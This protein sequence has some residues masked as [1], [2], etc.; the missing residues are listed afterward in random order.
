[1]CFAAVVVKLKTLRRRLL[2]G[3]DT[4]TSTM[5]S[6]GKLVEIAEPAV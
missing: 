6:V 3:V 2:K 1:V 5:L 4:R